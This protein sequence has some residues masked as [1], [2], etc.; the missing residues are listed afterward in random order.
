MKKVLGVIVAIIIVWIMGAISF[1]FKAMI[2]VKIANMENI[3]QF[4]YFIM[5]L[6]SLIPLI[7]AIWLIKLSWRKITAKKEQENEAS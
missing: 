1:V 5:G 7:I 3:S 4:Q 6:V 2:E